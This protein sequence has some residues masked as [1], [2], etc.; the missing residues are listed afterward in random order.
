MANFSQISTV[1]T[2]MRAPMTWMAKHLLLQ[3]SPA[4]LLSPL[5]S[6]SNSLQLPRVRSLPVPRQTPPPRGGR[7]NREAIGLTKYTAL[8]PGE[9]VKDGFFTL[10]EAVGGLE[11]CHCP[12]CQGAPRPDRVSQKDADDCRSW[13][14]RWTAGAWPQE[15]LST[16]TTM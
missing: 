15:S 8:E 11:V 6:Q 10:F 13:T 5:I 2:S 14:R 7:R 9:L 1:S 3:R 16:K 4:R 12:F